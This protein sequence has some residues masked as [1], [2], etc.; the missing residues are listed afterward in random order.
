MLRLVL[1]I[2]GSPYIISITL[3]QHSCSLGAIK[4]EKKEFEKINAN[5]CITLTSPPR[6]AMVQAL[7]DPDSNFPSAQMYF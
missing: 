2:D 1:P 6:A 3:Q 5:F 4:G 7:A